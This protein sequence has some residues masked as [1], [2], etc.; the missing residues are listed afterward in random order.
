MIGIFK[1]DKALRLSQVKRLLMNGDQSWKTIANRGVD[2]HVLFNTG[3][4]INPKDIDKI[5]NP[6]WQEVLQNSNLFV[7]KLET[8]IDPTAVHNQQLW[9]NRN[10]KDKFYFITK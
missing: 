6:F 9:N 2:C 10:V 7:D 3:G 5:K 4:L 8:P 1:F